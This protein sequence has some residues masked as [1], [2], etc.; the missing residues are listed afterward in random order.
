METILL[1][2][3]ALS[4]SGRKCFF[5]L[6][7]SV[8]VWG[9]FGNTLQNGF[10]WD[11]NVFIVDN[12]IYK[13]FD[14]YRIFSSLANGVEYLPTRDLSY[15]LD[16]FIWGN[17]PAGF[18]FSNVVY[19]WCCV[20]AVF[21]LAQATTRHLWQTEGTD[22]RRALLTGFIT[23]LLF[24]AHP[25][26]SEVVSFIT[27]RNAL[28]S[29]LLF[30]CSCHV[31][32]LFL[33][34]HSG[35]TRRWLLYTCA[36]VCFIASLLAKVTGI[37]LPFILAIYLAFSCKNQ[38]I[39]RVPAL[40][41]FFCLSAGA[42]F[43]FKNVA[44]QTHV[45]S[46]KYS[47]F[48]DMPSIAAKSIQIVCF[49]L[50]KLLLPYGYS[51][52]YDLLF[53]RSLTAPAVIAMASGLLLAALLAYGTRKTRPYIMFGCAWFI[54]SLL[55]VLNIFPTSPIVADRYAFL[56]SFGILYL[57]ASASVELSGRIRLRRAICGMSLLILVWSSVS[58]A[59]NRVWHSDVT[60][61]E[62]T[63][64]V[65]PGAIN[66]YNNLGRRY[67]E[68]NHNDERAFE[69]FARAQENNPGDPSMDHFTGLRH[70]LNKDTPTAIRHFNKA[71]G[72]DI[73]FIETLYQ[74]GLVYMESGET[75]KAC[76]YFRLVTS[77]RDMDVG[78]SLKSM[79]AGHLRNLKAACKF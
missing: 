11:D 35:K 31:Y 77:S 64:R 9:T 50:G 15:A 55:P 38:R 48:S 61:W 4:S 24:A 10:V 33:A 5:L 18:H 37:V 32:L 74:L 30:F 63:I 13:Q 59:R 52:E 42:F 44:E 34:G 47:A 1:I 46:S 57:L 2:S 58:F 66:A 12:K 75:A 26:H 41:P 25:I 68:V 14:V 3:Q 78:I 16:F 56:P 60:L 19:Y 71:L 7:L 76:E 23:A 20:I 21:Y 49:Y 51:A 39:W 27:C 67:F 45:V 62:D 22:D 17:N 6:I 43:F 69:M 29:T 73:E 53:H 8:V 70:Y 72:R 65:S 54:L 36:A 40:I 79:A 28:L